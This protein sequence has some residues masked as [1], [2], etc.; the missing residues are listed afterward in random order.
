MAL[1]RACSRGRRPWWRPTNDAELRIASIVH[2]VAERGSGAYNRSVELGS[3]LRPPPAFSIIPWPTRATN[4]STHFTGD[5]R[6]SASS[7]AVE[8]LPCI[9]RTTRGTVGASP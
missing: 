5:I 7:D 1:G 6:S 3:I 8:W 2:P 9:W 4:S